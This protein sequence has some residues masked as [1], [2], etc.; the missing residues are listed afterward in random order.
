MT[1]DVDVAANLDLV[2]D[3]I[4][5]AELSAGRPT[6]AARL[7]AVSK[8]QPVEAIRPALAAGHR[9]YG[10][11]RVQEA[12]AKWPELKAEFPDAR[13]HLIGPLQTNKVKQAVALFDAIQTL[14][15]PKLA[16][17]IATEIARSGKE[18]DCFIEINVGEEEQKAG[19][20]PQEADA[21]I[22]MCR[23]DLA[24]PIMGLMCIPPAAAEP[25]P[26]FALLA[27]IAERNEL[28]EISMGMSADYE[29]AIEFG[30]SLVRVGT[31]IF[32]PRRPRPD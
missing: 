27:K 4:N 8:T 3:Q 14:D 20:A 2:L 10:E 32:G 9:L 29:T 19:I 6:G 23:D 18:I 26:Y 13:L 22:A 5:Q 15:R 16:K 30:A 24:L 25:A 21:F 1:D 28:A 31:A 12:Q 17:A 11:N 7:V